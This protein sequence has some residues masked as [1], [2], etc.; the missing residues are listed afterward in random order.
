[1]RISVITKVSYAATIALS[2]LSGV[3]LVLANNAADAERTAMLERA[4]YKQLALDLANASDHL[5]NEA[6]R[7]TVFGDKRHFDAYWH[8]VKETKTRDRV[9]Q[10]LTQL[11]APQSEL[12]LIEEAKRKSDTLISLED[13]SM[14]AVAAGDL[15]KAQELMFGADY[16]RG[17][18]EIVAPVSRFQQM[19]TE[20]TGSTVEN[21]RS[22]AHLLGLVAQFSIALT[23]LSFLAILYG[24]LSRR[25]V[26]P[27]VRMSGVVTE[28]ANQNYGVDVPERQRDD[29]IGDIARAVQ[30][31]KESGIARQRLEAEQAAQRE[32]RERHNAKVEALVH[33][34]EGTVMSSLRTVASAATEL[35]ST[36]HGMASLADQANHQAIASAAAAEQTSANVQTVASAAEEMTASIQEISRQ[37]ATSNEIASKAARQAHDTTGS[38]RHLAEAANRIGEVVKLIQDIASQ[39]N[40]LALNATIEAARAGEAGKGFAVVASEVKALANQTGK[41]TEE[42]GQQI[43]AVQSAT[44]STVGAIEGIGQTITTINEIASAIAAAIEEQNATTG[45]I[46]RNVQQAAR[47]TEQVSGN[48]VEVRQAATQTGAAASQVLGASGELSQQAEALRRD[49][50]TFLANIRAA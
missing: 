34:F 7:Y 48:I 4:E 18:A 26:T 12:N 15:R 39:T 24:V 37:V 49:V 30:V 47:G 22:R 33:D 10:R 40:L 28:L 23:A 36:A 16:D 43:A 11:G 14:K 46:T 3:S 50:E 2:V 9:V 5:T 21:A 13:A 1:M 6:R 35:D 32:A 44:Q 8:E 25:A 17:K 41:A 20:R 38:V 31:L 27:L 19:L 29:E 45:E 42:I